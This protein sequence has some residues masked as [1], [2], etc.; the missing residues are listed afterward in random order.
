MRKTGFARKLPILTCLIV[1]G[2]AFGLTTI[3]NSKASENLAMV[4]MFE[5]DEAVVLPYALAMIE[6]AESLEAAARQ[7]VFYGFYHYGFPYF[8][9]SALV[10]LP[11]QWTGQIGNIPLVM[12][13]LR[14]M[15]SA[16]PMLLALLLLVYLGDGFKTYRSPLLLLALLSVPAVM[17]NSFWWHPD[18]LVT[19]LMVAAIFFLWR[20]RLRLG[21]NFLL[22]A[23]LI[24]IASALKLAG[25]FFFLA[26]GLVILSALVEKKAAISRAVAMGMAYL[27][28]M[29]GSFV[30]AN[31]FLLSEWARTEYIYTFNKQV[32]LVREGYEVFYQRGIQ[33]AFPILREYYGAGIILIPALYAAVSGLFDPQRR[34]LNGIILANF[35]PLTI[36]IF[37][38]T[39]FKFQ[40]WLP[41][42]LPLIACVALLLP[43]K[44]AHLLKNVCARAV[45]LAMSAIAL[46]QVIVLL[47][48][49]AALWSERTARA[50]NNERLQFYDRVVEQLSPWQQQPLKVYYDY[51]LY[52]PGTPF[53][54]GQTTFDLLTYEWAREADFD[55]LLLLQQ[56][57][58]DYLHPDAQGID[59]EQFARNQEF[60]RDA[61]RGALAGY[62]LLYRDSTGLI[63]VRE[64]LGGEVK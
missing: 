26:V 23:V 40:Y 53:W 59:A 45:S 8:G 61:D 17:R 2:I 27:A 60:Y 20:D 32:S 30:L 38:V 18:G 25:L 49:A 10:L 62:V 15:V 16:L 55:V 1:A 21:G 33:A 7:F 6:P 64:N 51:R 50:E 5:P 19:L 63:F 31:P 56:R 47:G 28:V 11:I 43:E 4:Q 57:I 48:Q 9:Y 41:A 36:N 52:F 54:Q 29:A 14:Q 37:F 13:A 24:G 46:V 42:V 39:H 12:L 34:L 58:R 35:I 3:T 44:P 22:S